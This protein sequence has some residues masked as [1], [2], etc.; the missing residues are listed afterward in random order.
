MA[1]RDV[2]IFQLGK[3]AKA[4]DFSPIP[5]RLQPDEFGEAREALDP[6][7]VIRRKRKYREIPQL[8]EARQLLEA[9]VVKTIK[10]KIVGRLDAKRAQLGKR[11]QPFEEF[12]LLVPRADIQL[13]LSQVFER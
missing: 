1:A 10:A 13:Q 3:T 5:K 8:G 4:A 11:R 7:D 2:E 12:V 6:S 9:C